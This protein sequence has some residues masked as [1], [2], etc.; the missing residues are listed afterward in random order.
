MKTLRTPGPEFDNIEERAGV[1]SFIHRQLYEK[2][3]LP[4]NV[5]LKLQT[6]IVTGSNT[7][8]GLECARQL[9][10]Y[11]L[12]K[13]IVAVRNESKGEDARKDLLSGQRD[14]LPEIEVW[15]LDL[16]SYDSVV[17]FT[18]RAKALDRLDIVVL[19]A[20]LS[21]QTYTKVAATGH[22]ETIQV[23]VLSTALL[24]I[25]LLGIV[26]AKKH[27]ERPGRLA[28]VQSD[29]ASWAKF[30]EKDAVPLLP[31]LDEPK[32]MDR[33]DRY[34]TSKLLAQLFVT[35]LSKRVSP[36]VAII[37]MPNPGWV[38][39]T[40]LGQTQGWSIGDMIVSVPRRLLGRSPSV[41]ARLVT[42]GAVAIGAEAHGQYV[43]DGK[44]QPKA[45]F[46]YSKDGEQ[47]AKTLWDEVMVELSFAGVDDILK[48]LKH[49]A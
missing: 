5:D 38:Y 31:A 36:S 6:A 39:G 4:E 47:V 27:P 40:G 35:E 48:E 14:P 34:F 18:K 25:L 24:A 2:P 8:L 46:V 30:Q 41:G 37:T 45:P 28:W 3:V 22:E 19:N 9:L 32:N 7:G 17:A 49:V 16:S 11:G 26:K 43:E 29:T 13:L 15:H 21:N 23:N 10:D 44:V 12:G 33:V 42:V 20:G 1:G